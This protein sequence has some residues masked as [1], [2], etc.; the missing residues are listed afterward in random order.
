MTNARAVEI[1]IGRLQQSRYARDRAAAVALVEL[2]RQ[3][4]GGE[5][6]I[7]ELAHPF[8]S[9]SDGKRVMCH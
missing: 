5:S 1:A 3:L 6:N 4:A 2:H 8:G 9:G 7:T